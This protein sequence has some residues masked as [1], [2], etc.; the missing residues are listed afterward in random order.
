[1]LPRGLN[2]SKKRLALAQFAQLIYIIIF[3]T[4]L[5]S[6]AE[7]KGVRMFKNEINEIAEEYIRYAKTKKLDHNA[8]HREI[9][10]RDTP[11]RKN[12]GAVKKQIISWYEKNVLIRQAGIVSCE[13]IGKYW[14][15]QEKE[16]E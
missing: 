5:L 1:M 11:F 3:Q 15:T 16:N 8:I 13:G 4:L 14:K 7:L 10:G 12:W 2:W 6:R 9:C